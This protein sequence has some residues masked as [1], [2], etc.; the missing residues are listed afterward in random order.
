MD[1]MREIGVLVIQSLGT[2][3]LFIVVLRF[4][5][6]LAR[7]DFYNPI[8]QFVVKATNPVL[9]PLRRVIPGFGGVDIASILL[10]LIVHYIIIQLTGLVLGT[11]IIPPL[12]VLAWSA[13]ATL[14][15]VSQIYFWGLLV[16]VIASWIAPAGGHP[17]LMLLNQLMQPILGP[18]QRILPN[19]GGLD[20]SPIFAFLLLNV[21]Q[22]LFGSLAQSLGITG[23][24]TL[25]TV[26]L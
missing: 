22:I 24:I 9:I 25:L 11:G 1:P 8:S 12:T 16:S 17:A 4:L 21:F 23:S 6:Q 7:A 26:G 14:Y 18:I 2:L 15:F 20:I 10:A 5:L 19:M 13:I 3:Y